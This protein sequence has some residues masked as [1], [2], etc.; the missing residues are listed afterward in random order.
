MSWATLASNQWVSFNDIAGSGIPLNSGQSHTYTNQFITKSEAITKYNLD[1][2]YLTLYA[3]NQ[4]VPKSALVAGVVAYGWCMGYSTTAASL[5][6]S[7]A[8]EGCTSL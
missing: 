3:S 6:C 7:D 4:W 8:A 1:T 5:A 2:S